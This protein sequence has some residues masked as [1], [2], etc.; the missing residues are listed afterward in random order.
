M[1]RRTP[2]AAARRSTTASPVIPATRSR[3]ASANVSGSLRLGQDGGRPAQDAASRAAQ[4]R[5]AIHP[6]NGRLQPRPV[7]QIARRGCPMSR[8]ASRA[9]PPPRSAPNSTCRKTRPPLQYRS[10]R[11]PE[12][13]KIS[14]FFSTLLV[15]SP[16]VVTSDPAQ[17]FSA[18][19]SVRPDGG[20]VEKRQTSTKRGIVGLQPRRA[21]H[22]QPP[23]G[24]EQDSNPQSPMSYT[25][26]VCSRSHSV[27]W[28]M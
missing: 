1:S 12:R 10:L 15:A 22:R 24:R 23:L 19:S 21:L 20:T 9:L 28:R 6:R 4:G 27:K 18:R 3:S 11:K 14:I 8:H 25:S 5:S 26:S 16:T 7:A 2:A 17:P 13:P